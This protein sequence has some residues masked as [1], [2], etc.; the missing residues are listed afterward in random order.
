MDIKRKKALFKELEVFLLFKYKEKYLLA[1]NVI[2]G[3]MQIILDKNPDSDDA[4]FD[5]FIEMLC[6]FIINPDSMPDI[7]NN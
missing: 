6:G 4:E 3:R 7:K 2:L 1:R 5:K